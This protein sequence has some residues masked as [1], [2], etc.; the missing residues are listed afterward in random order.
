MGAA[1]DRGVVH[2]LDGLRRAHLVERGRE[3]DAFALL[4]FGLEVAGRQQVLMSLVA[5]SD[6]LLVFEVVVP[7]GSRDELRA[8]LAGLE[9]E[10]GERAVET[11]FHAVYGRVGVTVRLH[12][13]MRQGMLVAEG[14]ERAQPQPRLGVSIDERVADHQLRALVDPEHLLAE[15]DTAHAVGDR[16]GRRILE[17]GDVLVT[18][19]LVHAGETVQGQVERLVVL[20]DRFVERRE[21]DVGPAA[22]VDGGYHQPVVPPRVAA[23]DG[24]AHV[25][26]H[27]VRREHLALERVL[28]IAQFAFVEGKC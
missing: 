3:D 16:G 21:E 7:V 1:G 11:A 17:V 9:V 14:E 23:D 28:Q 10:P 6:V 15:D 22:V 12:V 18:A 13:G 20:D 27:S 5:A 25:A 4:E 24:R 19:G 26:A 8:G 2:L